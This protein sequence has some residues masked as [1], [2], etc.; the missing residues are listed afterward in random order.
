MHVCVFVF[1]AGLYGNASCGSAFVKLTVCSLPF[2][3]AALRVLYKLLAD[4]R[5]M[6]TALLLLSGAPL[7]VP[8]Y[9]S[10]LAVFETHANTHACPALECWNFAVIAPLY[11]GNI[12]IVI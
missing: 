2:V 3:G 9:Y 8:S 12:H 5:M 10:L 4:H 11:L 6:S 7:C 1:E